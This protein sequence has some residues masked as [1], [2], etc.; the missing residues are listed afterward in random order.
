MS[1]EPDVVF[2]PKYEVKWACSVGGVEQVLTQ[3]RRL[4]TN[5]QEQKVFS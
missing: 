4:A 3:S 2:K 1:V 5:T